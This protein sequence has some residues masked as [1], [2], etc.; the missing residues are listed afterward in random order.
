[1]CGV[2]Y[3]QEAPAIIKH[4]DIPFVG[5]SVSKPFLLCHFDVFASF[6]LVFLSLLHF[7]NFNRAL[8]LSSKIRT[9]AICEYERVLSPHPRP[10][11]APYPSLVGVV[12]G[13]MH[14]L[15]YKIAGNTEN[16]TAFAPIRYKFTKI[17][18]FHHYCC[19]LKLLNPL[20]HLLE[21][22]LNFFSD[23]RTN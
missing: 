12:V 3:N 18:E 22:Y 7:S 19:A 17:G 5:Q 15:I 10:V 20:Y 6:S 23:R 8:S 11:Y 21:R 13:E 14:C 9:E 2:H 16:R 1:M 4:L